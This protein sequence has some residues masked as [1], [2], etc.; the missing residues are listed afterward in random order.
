MGINDNGFFIAGE[1]LEAE[2]IVKWVKSQ[3]LRKILKEAIEKTEVLKRR[4]RHCAARSLMILR[5]YKGRSKSVG[6]QQVSS[7]LLLSAINKISK[8]FPILKEARREVSGVIEQNKK[9]DGKND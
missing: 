2:K 6:R 5:N 4:F 9:M 8:D 3:D 1:S 7:F